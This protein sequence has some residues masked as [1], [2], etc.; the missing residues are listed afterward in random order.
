MYQEG[1]KEGCSGVC[2][3]LHWSARALGSVLA[4]WP[5]KI[6]GVLLPSPEKIGID[7][8]LRRAGAASAGPLTS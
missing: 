3:L 1:R 7:A 5:G 8:L 6:A 4:F 2:S